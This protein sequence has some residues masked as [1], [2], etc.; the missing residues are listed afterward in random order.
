MDLFDKNL[1]Q[2]QPLPDRLRPKTLDDFFGQE[3]L[4]GKDAPLRKMIEADDIPSM[5]F[6]GPPGTGKT[7]LAEI[8]A[9]RTGAHFN[10]LSAT[11]SGKKDLQ[12][13]IEE[14]RNRLKLQNKKTILFVDEIHRWN[15]AQQD[16]LLP[17]VEKGIITLIGATTENPSFEIVGALLSRARVFTLNQLNEDDLLAILKNALRLY[18]KNGIKMQFEEGSPALLIGLAGG[19]ARALLGALELVIKLKK[20]KNNAIIKKEDIK[21]AYLNANLFYDKGGEE[22]YNIISALH[23]SM[24]GS[25]SDAALYWLGRMLEAGE[26]P[27][28]VARRLVRFASEDI[29]LADPNALTQAVAAYQ[30]AHFLGMPECNTALAQVVVYMARAPKSNKL[31]A[32]YLEVQKDIREMP[33]EP[34]PLH[35]RNAPTKLMK[36]LEY[37]KDYKYNPAYKDPV[38]QE[39]MPS[40]LKNK[41]YFNE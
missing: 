40:G 7:T 20:E 11:S 1:N 21:N 32:A 18:F 29:G 35:L 16:S 19:D 30:A 41:K 8:I 2:N 25:D 3:H 27:L 37:G 12:A 28:Y 31:Y 38:K 14:A 36:D 33:R 23:K 5:I 22:H 4:V 15:K 17:Y 10:A 9:T 6:W 26:N 39:Y 34:V 24:R 13:I